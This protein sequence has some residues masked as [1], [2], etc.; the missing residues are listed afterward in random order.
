MENNAYEVDKSTALRT[1]YL[2][3]KDCDEGTHL[4]VSHSHFLVVLDSIMPVYCSVVQMKYQIC[5]S[6][7]IT[8]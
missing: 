8:P 2:K 5:P 4:Q 7:G 1:P 6:T 3:G